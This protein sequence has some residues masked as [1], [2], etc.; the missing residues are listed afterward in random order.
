MGADA[1]PARIA[2]AAR[3]TCTTHKTPAAAAGA[4]ACTVGWSRAHRTAA[5]TRRPAQQTYRCRGA[6]SGGARC[7]ALASHCELVARAVGFARAR[8]PA[9][10]RSPRSDCTRTQSRGW[11]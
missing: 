5:A 6:V 3:L 10:R 4:G 2:G 8:A 1:S 7:V 9:S 11:R